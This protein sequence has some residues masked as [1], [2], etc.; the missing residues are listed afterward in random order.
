MLFDLGFMLSC[1][2]PF[3]A[4]VGLELQSS[5]SRALGLGMCATMPNY[6]YHAC[7]QYSQGLVPSPLVLKLFVG[8]LIFFCSLWE[9]I[10]GFQ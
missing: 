3:I 8:F 7:W 9:V 4:E 2:I 10:G 6:E 5:A 1:Y